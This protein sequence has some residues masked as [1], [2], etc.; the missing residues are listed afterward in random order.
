[1][2][3]G[4]VEEMTAELRA[5]SDESVV[6]EGQP[7]PIEKRENDPTA[8]NTNEGMPKDNS[9]QTI[10]SPRAETAGGDEIPMKSEEKK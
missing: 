2:T 4:V 3:D 5:A 7:D 8:P 1:M 6:A 10:Q 9:D